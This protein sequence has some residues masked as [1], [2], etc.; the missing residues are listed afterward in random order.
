MRK[1][2]LR[3]APWDNVLCQISGTR[4]LRNFDPLQLD[5][6]YPKSN[7]RDFSQVVNPE[8][9]E[10]FKTFPLFAKA[11]SY[12]VELRPG[13][14]LVL[15]AMWWHAARHKKEVHIAVNFWYHSHTFSELLYDVTLPPGHFLDG[16]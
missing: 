5:R 2:W 3:D 13:E 11:R 1:R 6:L 9:M 16:L 14:I 7:D 12:L 15:P 8:D 10:V 4:V